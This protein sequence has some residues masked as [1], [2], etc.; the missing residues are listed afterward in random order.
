MTYPGSSTTGPSSPANQNAIVAATPGDPLAEAVA[1]GLRNLGWR[2]MVTDQAAAYAREARI[3]VALLTPTSVN[4][5]AIASALSVSGAALIPLVAGQTPPPY[6]PWATQ[7]IVFAGDPQ[8][9]ANEIAAAAKSLSASTIVPGSAPASGAPTGGSYVSPPTPIAYPA[10]N[11]TVQM[12]AGQ[13]YQPSPSYPTQAAPAPSYPAPAGPAPGAY[14]PAPYSPGAAPYAPP[15]SAPP[16][17]AKPRSR[18][19][20]IVGGIAAAVLIACITLGALAYNN[21]APKV[22]GV[23]TQT[24]QAGAAAA[25]PAATATPSIPANFTLYTDTAD[26]YRIAY[27]NTWQKSA[28]NGATDLLDVQEAADMVI[29]VSDATLSPSDITAQEKAFFQAVAASGKY[30]NLQGPTTISYGG[31]SWTQETADVTISNQTLTAA[32]LATNHGGKAYLIGY[33]AP[34]EIS[35]TLNSEDFQPM[36]NSFAFLS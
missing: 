1:A 34:K 21:F 27:P 28:S 29:G 4:S 36:L 22:F 19:P 17:P 24:A 35:T 20:W 15:Y 25:T 32:V 33:L 30:S 18:W 10:P 8:R 3:C 5:P 6:A 9:A 16:A 14:A 12:P 31:A 26:G 2:V 11:R 7:P 13:P 23:E